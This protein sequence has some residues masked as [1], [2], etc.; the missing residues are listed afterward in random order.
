M[1][2]HRETLVARIASGVL[3]TA[4]DRLL[5]LLGLLRISAALRLLIL[6]LGLLRLLKLLLRLL[7]GLLRFR[8]LS[9]AIGENT[10]PSGSCAPQLGQN[11]VFSSSE[12]SDFFN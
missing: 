10:L 2:T 8:Q 11:I 1:P 5:I 7:L 6:L 4:V 3:K 9:A 12:Y